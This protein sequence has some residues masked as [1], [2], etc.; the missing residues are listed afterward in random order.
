MELS[1]KCNFNLFSR[2]V[3]VMHDSNQRLLANGT[4]SSKR[5]ARNNASLK[6]ITQMVLENKNIQCVVS[7]WLTQSS[8]SIYF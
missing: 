1:Q 6:A 3:A 8:R 2:Y 7:G 4:G 5:E